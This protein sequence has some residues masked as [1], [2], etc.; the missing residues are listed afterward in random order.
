MTQEL[1]WLILTAG[2]TALFWLPYAT[3]WI[4]QRGLMG[5]MGN[6]GNS[7]PA[8]HGWADRAKRAHYNSVENLV[9][10]VPLVL[11]VHLSGVSSAFTVLAVKIY[12]WARLAYYPVYAIGIPV[13]RTLL[14][15][16]GFVAQMMLLYKLLQVTPLPA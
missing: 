12:F 5:A 15:I 11:A 9:T 3:D 6:P 14:F 2:V 1:Y 13:I 16:T 8:R 10:L 7:D 4:I